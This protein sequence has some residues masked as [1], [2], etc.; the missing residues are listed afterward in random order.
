MVHIGLR[1]KDRGRPGMRTS[2]ELCVSG[3]PTVVGVS[4][5]TDTKDALND[6]ESKVVS[7]LREAA[8]RHHD[9]RRPAAPATDRA[10]HVRRSVG[11]GGQDVGQVVADRLVEL[12]EGARL[13]GAVV[14]PADELRRVP[15]ARRPPCGRS[16]PRRP[17]RA[18]AARTTGPS[19]CSTGSTPTTAEC[20]R[21]RPPRWRAQF[22]GC[23]SH[24]ATSGWSSS[25]SSLRRA[26][27][28]A[29]MTP[30]RRELPVVAVEA[31]QQRA[32]RVGPA[33][34]H[35]VAGDDAVGGALVLDLEHQ[36]ACRARRRC[37]RAW[38]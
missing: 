30:D 7:Q 18:A 13:G 26:I 25:K 33:L 11:P 29:P 9:R 15:E 35:A 31:E 10:R 17:A 16:A 20:V 38:R 37:R 4:E 21:R 32:D 5:L 12:V 34:V 27:G 1:V 28:K 14:A 19:G 22:Q 3:L 6:A 8:D 23:S 36:R 2:V 24:S